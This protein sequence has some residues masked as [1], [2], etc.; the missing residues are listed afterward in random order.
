MLPMNRNDWGPTI[1]GQ[2]RTYSDS[3]VP[4]K[5]VNWR[6]I[7]A[8]SVR[9]VG[10][11]HSISTSW[12]GRAVWSLLCMAHT[13]GDETTNTIASVCFLTSERREGDA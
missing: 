2:S 5:C 12:N 7:S 6:H 3:C 13:K 9:S 11:A 1:P 8:S 10:G 4:S